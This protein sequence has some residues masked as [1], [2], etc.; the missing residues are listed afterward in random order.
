ML[1]GQR[2]VLIPKLQHSVSFSFSAD[3]CLAVA[4]RVESQA[5]CGVLASLLLVR[6]PVC[7]GGPLDPWVLVTLLQVSFMV[8]ALSH[9][10]WDHKL[11][12][13]SDCGLCLSQGFGF[14]TQHD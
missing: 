9:T 6:L 8:L 10:F 14:R 11:K 12:A 2:R 5:D 13:G 4:S 1:K 3:L 7:A